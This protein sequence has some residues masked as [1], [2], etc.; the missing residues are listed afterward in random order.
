MLF[1]YVLLGVR[2]RGND[3]LERNVYLKRVLLW[4]QQIAVLS[5][6]EIYFL[7]DFFAINI[8]TNK[9]F[10]TNIV[11]PC[12][13]TPWRGHPGAKTCRS[14]VLFMN[15]MYSCMGNG[16]RVWQV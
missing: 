16:L 10:I 4:T 7:N 6:Y 3:W 13:V 2:F 11:L 12:S 8:S 5:S 15:Y 14:S 1:K 9:Q